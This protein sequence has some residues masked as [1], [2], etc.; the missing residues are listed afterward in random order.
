MR[1][2]ALLCGVLFALMFSQGCS[3]ITVLRIAEIKAVETRIDSVSTA[4]SAKI[5]GQNELL[6][7]IRADMQARFSEMDKRIG[8][9]EGALSESQSRLSSID[10]KT[11]EIR[12]LQQEKEQSDS[13]TASRG[14]AAENLYKIAYGDF[15]AGR[16]DLAIA[17]FSD[18]LKQF[19][20]TPLLP[21]VEYVVSECYYAQKNYADA[22][23]GYFGLIKTYPA[24]PKVCPSLYKL[25]LIYESQKK[26][27]S[28]KMVWDKLI[29]QCPDSDEAKL[30]KSRQ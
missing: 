15:A 19:P 13:T 11:G 10:Q 7:I 12:R 6:R 5:D 20:Q 30:A 17:G 3:N 24:S 22:E 8:A 29:A 4:L 26:A 28:Q 2:V 23:T 27:K 21:D 16:Y 1:R 25:G 9:I 18:L 14:S